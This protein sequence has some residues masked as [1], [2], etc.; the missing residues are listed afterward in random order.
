[1]E[2]SAKEFKTI[3][4]IKPLSTMTEKE[5]FEEFE[6]NRE[7]GTRNE[8]V[9]RYIYLAEI[10]SKKFIKR[11]IDYEDIFQ[12]ASIGLLYSIERFE[13]SRGF[14]FSSFATPTIIGEIKKH[15]RDKGWSIRVPRRIQEMSKKINIARTSLYQQLQRTPLTKDIADFLECTEEE[16]FEILEASQ[17]YAL[18]SLDLT[19]EN[20]GEDK[21]VLFMDLIGEK[22]AKFELIEDRDFLEKT[23]N[24]LNKIEKEVLNERFF[25]Y[26]TQMQ[27]AKELK[28]SQMTVSRVEK[29][30]IEKF[31]RELRKMN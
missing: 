25:G 9:K 2:D 14:E 8:L 6:K 3:K 23:M 26:K 20:A 28:I 1:M 16:I 29:K 12:V 24:K 19:Y 5:L 15:F 10:L 31:R 7:T 4:S 22:D 13:T 27:I 30:A 11:G 17:V 18:K 21:D